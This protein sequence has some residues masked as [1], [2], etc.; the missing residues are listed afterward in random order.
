VLGA[1]SITQ[2]ARFD[3]SGLTFIGSG[4][5]PESAVLITLVKAV[6][7]EDY[8]LAG[9]EVNTSGAFYLAPSGK[10]VVMPKSIKP[11]WYSALAVDEGGARASAP[12]QVV[13][14]PTPTP[15]PVPTP[16]PA[17]KE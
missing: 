7:G 2:G 13:P 15:T 9:G 1:S 8:I 16:T 11:G 12:L 6:D 10:R 3:K 14:P 4:F 5:T 17:P